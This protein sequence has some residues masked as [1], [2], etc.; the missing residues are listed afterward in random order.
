MGNL[1]NRP[2]APA[3]P[4]TLEEIVEKR[5]Q[6][7][8]LDRC[9]ACDMPIADHPRRKGPTPAVGPIP[10]GKSP[11]HR[12]FR[13]ACNCIPLITGGLAASVTAAIEASLLL[14]ME[15]PEPDELPPSKKAKAGKA[16]PPRMMTV[17]GSAVPVTA[18]RAITSLHGTVNVGQA[19]TLITSRGISLPATVE[20]QVYQA[21]LV[22]IAVVV[23]DGCNL[24]NLSA[25][26]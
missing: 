13:L 9:G 3:C 21:E 23:L 11:S 20:L 26:V 19:V 6:G 16:T 25:M 12:W 17:R 18:R 1:I 4:L 22:D 7:N 15:L 10:Q 24:P 5:L 2:P 14:R 8:R